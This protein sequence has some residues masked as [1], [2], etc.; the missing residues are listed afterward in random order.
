M[1]EADLLE[2]EVNILMLSVS[3][4][5]LATDHMD[6]LAKDSTKDVLYSLLDIMEFCLYRLYDM[7]KD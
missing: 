3:T 2:R 7:L 4:G 1:T 5:Y 6:K